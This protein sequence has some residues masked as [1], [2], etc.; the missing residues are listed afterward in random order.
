MIPADR[1]EKKMQHWQAVITSACE[2]CGRACIPELVAPIEF[3]QALANSDEK[4]IKLIAS[5]DG[6]HSLTNVPEQEISS[7]V[8]LIGPEGGFS[9]SEL[10]QAVSS[11]FKVISLGPRIL[12]L[13]TAVVAMTTLI[14]SR[15][16]DIS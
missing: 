11:G 5:P 1:M 9:S 13:E 2:Q 3:T 12:R 4:Q 7:C 15:W 10:N 6:N 8:Y 16:G 14:Q